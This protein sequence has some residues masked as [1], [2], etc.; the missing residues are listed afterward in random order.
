MRCS[1]QYALVLAL[2]H[3][4]DDEAQ[5]ALLVRLEQIVECRLAYGVN[6]VVGKAGVE[7]YLECE[8]HLRAYGV[9]KLQARFARHFNIEKQHVGLFLKQW[10]RGFGV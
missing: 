7:H 6:H 3:A 10:Q 1:M 8:C 4:V 9:E 2:F 5:L